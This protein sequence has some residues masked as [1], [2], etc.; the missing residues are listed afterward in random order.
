MAATRSRTKKAADSG[1]TINAGDLSVKREGG[2]VVIDAASVMARLDEL[3]AK[4]AAAEDRAASAE[5]QAEKLS[6]QLNSAQENG[7]FWDEFGNKVS[8]LTSAMKQGNAGIHDK[9][10]TVIEKLDIMEKMAAIRKE[11]FDRERTRKILMGEPVEDFCKFRC[12]HCGR[13]EEVWN[14]REDLYEAHVENHINQ[15]GRKAAYGQR[16]HIRKADAKVRVIE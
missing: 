2:A 6:Q 16:Q 10:G 11:P 14:T 12:E 8:C 4:V 9:P 3:T 7:F 1:D 5:A 13:A 15:T